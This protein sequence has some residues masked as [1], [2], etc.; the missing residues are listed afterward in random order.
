MLHFVF[1]SDTEETPKYRAKIQ[2]IQKKI[3]EVLSV[4]ESHNKLSR[5]GHTAAVQRV[6]WSPHS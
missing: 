1:I 5:R 4:A 3:C 6:S 2:I